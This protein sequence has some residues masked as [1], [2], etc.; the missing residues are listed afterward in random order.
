M[1]GDGSLSVESRQLLRDAGV[2]VRYPRNTALFHEGSPST[3][4]LL[5]ETGDVKVTSSS[6]TGYVC[7]LAIRGP[8]EIVGEFGAADGKPRAAS[9]TTITPVTAFSVSADR[10][11]ELL[12][13]PG[14]ALEL[15]RLVSE[16]VRESDRR[17]LEFG[18]YPAAERIIRVLL[19]LAG[20]HQSLTVTTYQHDLA[21]AA[22]TSRESV[23]RTVRDL[24]RLGA[25]TTHHGQISISHVDVLRKLIDH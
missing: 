4:V 9:V 23:A 20:R 18:A 1:T 25:I 3:H 21:G 13:L 22:G 12:T 24:R 15:L 5:L 2:R 17:R 6:P 16:R 11:R 14:V 19:D 7:L 8:G 10:F